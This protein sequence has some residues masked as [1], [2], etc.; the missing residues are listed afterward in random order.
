MASCMRSMAMML[1]KKF[2]FKSKEEKEF[3]A[4]FSIVMP[5]LSAES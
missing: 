3:G 1:N 5:T 4:E 2:G